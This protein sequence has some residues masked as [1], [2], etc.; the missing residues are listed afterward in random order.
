M[1]LLVLVEESHFVYDRKLLYFTSMP[2]KIIGTIISDE[3]FNHELFSGFLN[4]V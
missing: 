3:F 2:P 1:W 4:A